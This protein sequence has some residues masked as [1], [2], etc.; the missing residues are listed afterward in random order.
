MRLI[1]I[2]CG[3]IF[4]TASATEL[5]A[6]LLPLPS[7]SWSGNVQL[8]YTGTYGNNEDTN[9][10]TGLNI[11]FEKEKWRNTYN[12]NGVFNSHN[13]STTA[14]HYASTLEFN[15]HLRKR[16]FMF[17]RNNSVYDAFNAY[18]LVINN[19]AGAGLRLI[20]EPNLSLDIQGGPGFRQST[21]NSSD[22]IVRETI[23]YFGA[24]LNW[25]ISET[26]AFQEMVNIDSGKSNTITQTQTTLTSDIINNFGISVSLS[27][28]HN[29][30][31][32]PGSTNTQKTDYLTELTFVYSF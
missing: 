15:Y 19:A 13:N 18:S 9:I 17:A 23:A 26:A 8:G 29:S 25:T 14:Q 7:A 3:L 24:T 32:P 31:I 2:L 1:I 30:Q 28:S 21:I 10:N 20:E 11:L 6:P 12:F 4:F 16:L 5:A 27:T 22:N